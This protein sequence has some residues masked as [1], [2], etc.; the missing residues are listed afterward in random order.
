MFIPKGKACSICKTQFLAK[1]AASKYC[2]ECKKEV[3]RQ[4]NNTWVDANRD[5]VRANHMRWYYRHEHAV[6]QNNRKR[7][8][9]WKLD[10]IEKVR[11]EQAVHIALRRGDMVRPTQCG[12]CQKTAKIHAH[13]PDYTKPLN[14]LWL[15]VSCHKLTHL[16]TLPS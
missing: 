15:C 12:Q 8:K 11:A 16:N 9:Q 5:R 1:G 10:N 4:Q 7:V 2:P 3:N 13:H 6:D 14:V